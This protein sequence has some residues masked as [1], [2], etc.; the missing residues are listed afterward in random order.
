MAVAG[1][2]S[3]GHANVRARGQR[4]TLDIQ[5]RRRRRRGGHAR[6]AEQ[7]NG[8]GQHGAL[9][10]ASARDRSHPASSGHYLMNSVR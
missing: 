6:G 5:R 9:H 4:S 3:H 7:Q 10:L 2:T 1:K 8:L